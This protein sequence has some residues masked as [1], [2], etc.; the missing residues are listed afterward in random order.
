MTSCTAS[1]LNC[2]LNFRLDTDAMV[3]IL[4]QRDLSK[5]L[6]TPQA[7]LPPGV[8]EGVGVS[9]NTSRLESMRM[10]C[11]GPMGFAQGIG[12]YCEVACHLMTVS[13]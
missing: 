5:N 12:T 4:S 2:E 7:R 13:R 8:S 6:G 9:R 10:P 11:D 3:L 1:A